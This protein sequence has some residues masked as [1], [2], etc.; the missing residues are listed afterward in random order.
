MSVYF[1]TGSG[2][3]KLKEVYYSGGNNKFYKGYAQNFTVV[4]SP[5]FSGGVDDYTVSNF[6]TSN[7]LKLQEFSPA[8][9]SWE[10]VIK[11]NSGTTGSTYQSYLNTTTPY[12]S[13][14]I[15]REANKKIGI[16]SFANAG[17]TTHFSLYGTTL[18][19]DNTDYWVKLIYNPASGYALY[20]ST[21]GTTY[22]LENSNTITT[23]IAQGQLLILG[24]D[25][26]GSAM[27]NPVNGS[28]DLSEC[29]IK[30]NGETWWTGLKRVGADEAILSEE[31][32]AED[33]YDYIVPDYTKISQIY[34]G[35]TLVFG[36]S[37][38]EPLYYCYKDAISN[39]Y[40]YAKSPL[41][42]DM[43]FYIYGFYEQASKS[44]QLIDSGADWKALNEEEAYFETGDPLVRYAAGDLYE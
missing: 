40:A 26:G 4:G 31:V 43:A 6:S 1:S 8:N 5:T 23:A 22:N 15:T 32:T 19:N 27:Q 44:S 30:I 28:I 34:K 38:Q 20:L 13:I 18:T 9:N 11:F 24:C 12:Q 35:S 14:C 21:D 2:V 25:M 39:L 41:G 3:K 29:Y 10:M 16:G 17:S 37:S 33:D 42:S 7:Y 36:E